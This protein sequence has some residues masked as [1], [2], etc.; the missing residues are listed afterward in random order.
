MRQVNMLKQKLAAGKPVVGMWASLPCPAVVEAMSLAG[1]DYIII[2]SEHGQ[3]NLETTI[4]MMRA[5]AVGSAPDR[6]IAETPPPSKSATEALSRVHHRAG[7]RQT[8]DA[9]SL[10]AAPAGR[11]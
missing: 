2:D 11:C 5:C 1:Y 6:P 7:V 9:E 3:L 4:D 8:I 10:W